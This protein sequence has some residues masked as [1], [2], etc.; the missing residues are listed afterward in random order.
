MN[1]PLSRRRAF[2]LVELLV[3]IAIIGILVALLLPAVQY[4]R[5]SARR[6]QCQNNLRQIGLAVQG[7]VDSTKYIPTGG[8]TPWPV[9]SQFVDTNTGFINGPDKQGFSW[10]FQILPYFEQKTIQ[11]QRDPA[12]NWATTQFRME[13]SPIESYFCP[14]RRRLSKQV[15]RYL[16]DYAGCTPS[17]NFRGGNTNDE[18]VL[19]YTAADHGTWMWQGDTWNVPANRQWYGAIIRTPIRW[20]GSQW[21]P[22]GSTNPIGFEGIKDGTTNVLLIGEKRLK[23]N[24]YGSG[25]WHD[26]RGWTDGWDPDTMRCSSA[27]FGSDRSWNFKPFPGDDIGY[28]F[29]AAHAEGM[30]FVFCDASVKFIYYNADRNLFNRLGHRLDGKTGSQQDL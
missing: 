11:D 22:N 24:Q 21:L 2:T 3:V 7:H 4:A 5:E 14:S 1:N 13:S 27:P 23:P 19:T 8:T 18:L 29:G 17:N 12:G 16:L 9:L 10:P 30:N 28:H 6:T 26:D 20:N 15:N 25:D